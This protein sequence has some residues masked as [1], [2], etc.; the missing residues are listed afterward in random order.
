[1]CYAQHGSLSTVTCC[2]LTGLFNY[3]FSGLPPAL[4]PWL[5]EPSPEP[6]VVLDLTLNKITLSGAVSRHWPSQS[7]LQP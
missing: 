3:F 4:S 6:K 5:T 1:M 2:V 7:L